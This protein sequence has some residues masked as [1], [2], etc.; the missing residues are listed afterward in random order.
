MKKLN[1]DLMKFDLMISPLVKTYPNFIRHM[2][3]FKKLDYVIVHKNA[4]ATPVN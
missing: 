3:S 1:F 2:Q 4:V